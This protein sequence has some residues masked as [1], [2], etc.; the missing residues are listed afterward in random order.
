MDTSEWQGRV[1]DS[2]A[3]EWRRTDRSFSSL[4]SVLIDRVH[5]FAPDARAIVDV[6]CGAGT[7]TFE[8]AQ[9]FPEASILGIDISEGLLAVARTRANLPNCRFEV[10]DA[11]RWRPDG[12]VPDLLV[13]RHGVMF[14]AD[15]VAAFR[16]LA[17]VATPNA[18]LMF[19]CFREARLNA[20]AADI[21]ALFPAPPPSDTRAPGPFAFAD[22]DH[23]REIL[24][25]AGWTQIDAEPV[26]FA[27]VAGDGD[28]PLEDAL[29]YFCRIGPAARA[30]RDLDPDRR[31]PVIEKLAALLRNHLADGTVKLKAAAWVWSAKRQQRKDV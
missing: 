27:Y 26:D 20:W 23:V 3:A 29:D 4:Q 7:T 16:H 10:A 30:L 31:P 1:G 2:W 5:A 6:G 21:L 13:S 22:P 15:P 8:L 25:Q 9:R 28:N 19:S 18:R 12:V 17:D 14:F 24:D 11:S